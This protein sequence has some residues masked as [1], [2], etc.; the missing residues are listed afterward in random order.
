MKV[1]T[2]KLKGFCSGNRRVFWDWVVKP[3][4]KEGPAF[5]LWVKKSRKVLIDRYSSAIDRLIAHL[6]E[7]YG[8]FM[9]IHPR[10]QGS[11]ETKSGIGLEPGSFLAFDVVFL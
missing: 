2:R 9:A 11:V 5:V 6:R 1:I 3:D 7:L 4:W 10:P 8:K